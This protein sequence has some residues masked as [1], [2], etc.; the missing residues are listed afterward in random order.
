MFRHRTFCPHQRQFLWPFESHKTKQKI[1][2]LKQWLE[3]CC[4]IYIPLV[5][6]VWC[7]R[8]GYQWWLSS[9]NSRLPGCPTKSDRR[10]WVSRP[11]LCRSLLDVGCRIGLEDKPQ[12]LD[13]VQSGLFRSLIERL[14]MVQRNKVCFLP[15]CIYSLDKTWWLTES[16]ILL[17]IDFDLF[18]QF[19]DPGN[20]LS[21]GTECFTCQMAM[22]SQWNFCNKYFHFFFIILHLDFLLCLE[23]RV[24]PV[25]LWA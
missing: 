14:P 11:R 18:L 16:W 9:P 23:S 2:N 3:H 8:S 7:H 13:C 1:L 20:S 21:V 6:F 4:T 22:I 24:N 12:R 17:M 25:E 19:I 10:T 5:R 15:W